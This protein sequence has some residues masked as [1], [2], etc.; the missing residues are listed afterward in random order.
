MGEQRVAVEIDEEQRQ[1]FMQALLAD[2]VALE[3]LL[4]DGRIETGV[5]RI[6]AEQ[7]M[8]LVDRGLRPAPL[9]LDV[10]E[11]AADPRLTTELARFNLEANL[12]PLLFG[13]DCLSRMEAELRDLVGKAAEAARAL[14]GDVLLTGILPTLRSSD[15]G[16]DNMTPRP[17]YHELNRA[18]RALRGGEFHVRIQGLDDFE[19]THDSV[20][21]ESCNTSFQI[22]F[23]VAPGELAALYNLAQAVTAPVLAAAVNSPL[24]LGRRLWHETRIALFERSIDTRPAARID[25]PHAPRVHFGDAWIKDSVL[26]IFREDIA[27]FRIIMTSDPGED[28]MAVLDRGE[29]P[30]LTALRVHNGT[31]YRWNRPCYGVAGGVAHLRI[32]NRAL[33]SGPTLL[34]EVANAA[35]YYGLMAALSREHDRIDRVMSFADAKA[36]FFAAARHGLKAQLTWIHGETFSAP[37]LIQG[38]LLPRAREGLAAAGIDPGDIDRYLGVIDERVRSGQTG[39]QWALSSFAALKGADRAAGDMTCRALCAAMLSHQRGDDPVHRWP[40]AP[41]IEDDRALRESYRVVGQFMTRDLFTVRPTDI[42]DFAASVMDWRHI[43]HVPVE[44]DQGRLVGLVSHRALLRLMARG[45]GRPRD[46][47]APPSARGG[48]PSISA[49][50]TVASIMKAHPI[51][52][53]PATPT[54]EAMRLMREHRVGCLPVVEGELLVGI[55][56]ER[57]LLEVATKLLERHL[58]DE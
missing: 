23:Q 50:Q 55:I 5:R 7:E 57:D 56:T 45:H 31:V 40:L 11:R 8:F 52:V 24:L 17:R 2:V 51:T 28:P 43:R 33:P 4:D 29:I 26:E 18:L 35:F 6:G 42:V 30:D 54:L 13:G 41:P 19:A 47:G 46:P 49:A 32:E 39:A 1:A 48:P 12:T 44:D 22:H 25:R 27:R 15:L 36:N 9:V 38:H 10:L 14:G 37:A 53:T 16:L 20:M 58:R 3:R 21:L 34:D